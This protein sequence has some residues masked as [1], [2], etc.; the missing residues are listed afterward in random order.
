MEQ[1]ATSHCSSRAMPTKQASLAPQLLQLF[2]ASSFCTA[3]RYSSYMYF[4]VSKMSCIECDLNPT[5]T[6]LPVDIVV[7]IACNQVDQSA[8]SGTIFF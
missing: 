2:L 8:Y 1:R 4:I 5:F 3:V 6:Y 7:P